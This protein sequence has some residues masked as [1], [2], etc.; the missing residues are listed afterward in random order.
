MVEVMVVVVVI[1]LAAVLAAPMLRTTAD[2]QLRQA[3]K[4]I[5][6]DL[7]QAQVRSITKGDD[8]TAA[9]F[10]IANDRYF[11]AEESDL[12]TPITEGVNGGFYRVTLGQGRASGVGDVSITGVNF[13]PTAGGP[14]VLRYGLYGELDRASD[15]TIDL[16]A[17]GMTLRVTASADTGEASVGTIGGS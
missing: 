1:G 14:A 16:A 5:A 2:Y 9:V 13:A 15:A 11:L 7:G 3:G 8:R 12:T 4:L 6:A 10:D 17:D